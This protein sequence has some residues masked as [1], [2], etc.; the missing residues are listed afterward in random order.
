MSGVGVKIHDVEVHTC[1]E[2]SDDPT[3]QS[4]M[5]EAAL[6]GGI[7]DGRVIR[8]RL[9]EVDGG[10]LTQRSIDSAMFSMSLFLGKG[11]TETIVPSSSSYATAWERVPDNDDNGTA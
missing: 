10:K 11:R 7:K 6:Q 2:C 1:S 3:F 8:L 9:G 5:A 4:M